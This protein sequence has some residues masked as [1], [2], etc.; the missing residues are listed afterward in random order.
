[1]SEASEKLLEDIDSDLLGG[2]ESAPETIQID[3][4][5]VELDGARKIIIGLLYEHL[6]EENTL[7][8]IEDNITP[9]K[10]QT[11]R[12]IFQ[13]WDNRAQIQQQ[14]QNGE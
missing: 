6:G 5:D 2:L 11:D 13:I 8:I 1:M 7:D 4:G 12:I 14:L 10:E 9:I 3:G